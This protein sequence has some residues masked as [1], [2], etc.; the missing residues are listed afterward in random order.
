M[1]PITEQKRRLRREIRQ[2]LLPL[3]AGTYPQE[4]VQKI[5]PRL[6]PV[7]YGCRNLMVY[8]NL[9]DEFPTYPLL[10]SLYFG[11]NQPRNIVIPWCCGENLRLFRLFAADAPDRYREAETFGERLETGAFGIKEPRTA[12]RDRP[13]CQFDP[14]QLDVILVPGRGFDVKRNRLGRGKGYYDRFFTKI[15]PRC[16][17]IGLAFDQQII[18]FLPAEPHDRPM[19]LLITENREISSGKDCPGQK[20]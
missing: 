12:L 2:R 3:C 18:E 19:D 15:S 6:E 20:Y 1:E 4:A 11:E 14:K 16:R 10:W 7:L 8:L 17:L 9:P 5:R 13:E